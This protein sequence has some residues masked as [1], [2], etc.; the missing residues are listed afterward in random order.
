MDWKTMIAW[1]VA[2]VSFLFLG[3]LVALPGIPGIVG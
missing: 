3:V 1:L 2:G